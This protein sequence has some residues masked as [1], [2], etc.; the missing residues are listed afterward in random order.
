[1]NVRQPLLGFCTFGTVVCGLLVMVLIAPAVRA[2]NSPIPLPIRTGSNSDQNRPLID[3]FIK[4]QV[5]QLATPATQHDARE[6]LIAQ[7]SGGGAE[8]PSGSFMDVYAQELNQ[9]LMPLLANQDRSTQT[10]RLNAAIAV[11]GVADR[12]NNVRLLPITLQLLKDQSDAVKIW[13]LRAARS[14]LPPAIAINQQANLLAAIKAQAGPDANP[15]LLQLVYAALSPNIANNDPNAAKI[16]SVVVPELQTL[17]EARVKQFQKEVPP[18]ILS[19]R[20]ATDFLSAK[21]WVQTTTEQRLGTVQILSDL[22]AVAGE[23]A[24]ASTGTDK[25]QLID[26][27]KQTTLALEAC[28]YNE[29]AFDVFNTLQ[30]QLTVNQGTPSISAIT[31]KIQPL[32]T[33]VPGWGTIKPPPHIVSGTAGGSATAPAAASN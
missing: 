3:S 22:I 32:L 21:A 10:A 6:L 30:H 24:D 33:T 28:A 29:K 5:D 8:A 23:R 14:V 25:Q 26:M 4:A 19:V 11:A 12:V 1:M 13:G 18:D 27:V 7:V 17:L 20:P 31:S 16:V 15:M 9:L 2:D